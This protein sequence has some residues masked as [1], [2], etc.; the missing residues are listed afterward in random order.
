MIYERRNVGGAKE[1][2]VRQGHVFRNAV[3][4]SA[5]QQINTRSFRF[6]LRLKSSSRGYSFGISK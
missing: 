4:M 2:W 1:S 6:V 3:L 5:A